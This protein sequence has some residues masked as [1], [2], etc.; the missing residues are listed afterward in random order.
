MSASTIGVVEEFGGRVEELAGRAVRDQVMAGCGSITAKTSPTDLAL[1]V[2]G[3]IERL[4]GIAPE[5]T[6]VQIM[7]HCGV[8]CSRVNSIVVERA[9]ARRQKYGSEEAFLAAEVKRSTAGSRLE[10][11][12]N[13]LRQIYTPRAFTRPMRCYCGLVKG[14]PEGETMSR[15]YCSCS[16]AFV[17]TLWEQVL[18]RPVTVEL[19]ESALTGSSECQFRIA[20]G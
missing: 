1:W 3:A 11:V 2:K 15:T 20:I 18:G 4:D 17:R 19:V 14:L 9:K 10:R 16:K 12:G 7:E 5:E 8:N 13:V 6:R